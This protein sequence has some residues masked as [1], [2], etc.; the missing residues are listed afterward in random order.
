M[1]LNVGRREFQKAQLDLIRMS[2][3][4]TRQGREHR[5]LIAGKPGSAS[6][7]LIEA[8]GDDGEAASRVTLLGQRDDV[9][10]CLELPT[11]S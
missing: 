3:Q 6:D 11:F 7:V 4:L 1:I 5:V 2:Q 8:L 10:A 9:G